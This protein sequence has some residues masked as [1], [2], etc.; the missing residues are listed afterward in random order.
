MT[1]IT[2]RQIVL[3][4]KCSQIFCFLVTRP[5]LTAGWQHGSSRIMVAYVWVPLWKA[6]ESKHMKGQETVEEEKPPLAAWLFFSKLVRTGDILWYVSKRYSKVIIFFLY[7]VS[8]FSGNSTWFSKGSHFGP[9]LSGLGSN[10]VFLELR[11]DKI[12]VVVCQTFY[13]NDFT[14]HLLSNDVQYAVYLH[15][16][17]KL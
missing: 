7:H 12:P 5:F 16:C 6:S 4:F 8:L 17:T 3:N 15:I 2:E 1:A 11:I 10:I 9:G 14:F 13:F